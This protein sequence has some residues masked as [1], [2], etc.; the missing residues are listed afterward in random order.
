MLW[1]VWLHVLAWMTAIAVFVGVAAAVRVV[2]LRAEPAVYRAVAPITTPLFPIG[3]IATAIGI[4]TG[5]VLAASFGYG[6]HWL[7]GAYVL[8]VVAAALG[9]GVVGRW[10]E[11]LAAAD[12]GTYAAIRSERFP[13]V[14]LVITLLCW[15]TI[16]W[17]MIVKPG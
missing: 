3:G 8:T 1:L 2:A 13:Q 16:L 9:A 4:I 15:A 11:R 17:L 7:I 12:D 14:A 10:A 6:A 5:L